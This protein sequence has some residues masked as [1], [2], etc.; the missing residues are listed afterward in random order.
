MMRR[1]LSESGIT[2]IEVVLI[3][4][5]MA[6]LAKMFVPR[7]SKDAILMHKVYSTAHD[8]ASDLRY[9][10]RLAT[11]GGE[12][13]NPISDPSSATTIESKFWFE[14]YKTA[15]A[16]AT[17]SWRVYSY[18]GSQGS[19]VKTN[20][21]LSDMVIE[22]PATNAVYFDDRGVPY[23]SSTSYFDV[24]DT[25]GKYRWRVSV[26]RGTGYVRLRQL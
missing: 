23:P 14:I 18:H 1:L 3:I 24:A 20:Q 11:T 5:I 25:E 17:D 8:M 16:S 19:P 13:G 6:I 10:R 2:I 4:V 7:Y 15:G 26:E 9:A 12:Q 21:V 22:Q